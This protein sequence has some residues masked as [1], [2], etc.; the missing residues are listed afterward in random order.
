MA[1]EASEARPGEPPEPSSRS[2]DEAP[3]PLRA[4]AGAKG[5]TLPPGPAPG[6]RSTPWAGRG[7]KQGAAGLPFLYPIAGASRKGGKADQPGCTPGEA[8]AMAEGFFCFGMWLYLPAPSPLLSPPLPHVVQVR[9]TWRRP[10]IGSFKPR[11]GSGGG[12]GRQRLDEWEGGRRGG[13]GRRRW[14]P[15]GE[16]R[17]GGGREGASAGEGREGGAQG[18]GGK[19]RPGGE[20]ERS[21]AVA[22][23]AEARRGRRRPEVR[24]RAR[25]LGGGTGR[26]LP[27]EV[28]GAIAEPS[29]A[30][31][32]QE[33]EGEGV[34]RALPLALSTSGRGRP[35]PSSRRARGQHSP[36]SSR[37][38]PK[39]LL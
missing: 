32:Y 15:G 35:S 10:P 20:G 34:P 12:G 31:Q 25:R 11:R 22:R 14:S 8:R 7:W 1:S 27:D 13:A 37:G 39:P 30:S 38:P 21:R 16:P 3:T 5:G 4:A 23:E 6:R 26:R 19:A 33:P 17:P 2:E 24:P 18:F 28:A 9:D 36:H 29:P